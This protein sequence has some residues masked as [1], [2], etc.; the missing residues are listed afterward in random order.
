MKNLLHYYCCRNLLQQ[1]L[2]MISLEPFANLIILFVTTL[3][4]LWYEEFTDIKKSVTF[5][6]VF[7]R[8]ILIIALQY[9]SDFFDRVTPSSERLGK[10]ILD[11][12][13][14]GSWGTVPV[15]KLTKYFV[16]FILLP[17]WPDLATFRHFGKILT[18]HF[19]LGIM[20][21]IL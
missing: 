10:I 12:N 9:F 17:V 6:L 18:I 14:D 21:S 7:Y 11:E 19:F 16:P 13:T 15:K 2:S 1:L 20:L 5:E 4:K 8:Q 3:L